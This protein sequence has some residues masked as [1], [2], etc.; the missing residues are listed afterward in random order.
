MMDTPNSKEMVMV[1]ENMQLRV[2]HRLKSKNIE[3]YIWAI[4]V[5]WKIVLKWMMKKKM[6][7]S[8]DAQM[9]D[10]VGI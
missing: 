3:A 4:H 5:M 6:K 8:L 2:D 1:L 10:I 7:L 9:N